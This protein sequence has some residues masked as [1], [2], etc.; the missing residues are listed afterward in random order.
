MAHPIVDQLFA[1]VVVGG[2]KVPVIAIV[3]ASLAVLFS[4][5]VGG[6]EE[7]KKE[8]KNPKALDPEEWRAFPL[9][10]IETISHD[11]KK[12]RFSL[13]SAQHR[14]GLPIGQHIS[15]KYTDEQGKEVQRSYTPASS[16]DDLGFVDFV[17]KVY[18]KCEPR[19]PEGMFRNHTGFPRLGLTIFSC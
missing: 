15:L 12:F 7:K 16:D 6:P 4:L 2:F 18:F 1:D 14:V 3:L 17:V 19:F 8:N 13:P 11:V 5:V 10:E 9:V